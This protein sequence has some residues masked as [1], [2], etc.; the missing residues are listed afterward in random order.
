MCSVLILEE[1]QKKTDASNAAT[2]THEAMVVGVGVT[3]IHGYSIHGPASRH[4]PITNSTN[5]QWRHQGSH[6]SVLLPPTSWALTLVL[7]HT[8]LTMQQLDP[9]LP[10]S[11]QQCYN[12]PS[13][14]AVA[15]TRSSASYRS[16]EHTTTW[17]SRVG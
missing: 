2:A 6:A 8:R 11:S 12:G 5:R 13:S 9:A 10:A 14:T 16:S 15:T 3:T 4:V 7:H 1:A 17:Q